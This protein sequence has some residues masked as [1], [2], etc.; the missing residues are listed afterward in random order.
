ML[1]IIKW[2]SQVTNKTWIRNWRWYD[3]VAL[4]AWYPFCSIFSFVHD[5]IFGLVLSTSSSSSVFMIPSWHSIGVCT[6]ATH[7]TLLSNRMQCCICW[8][9]RFQGIVGRSW[10]SSPLCHRQLSAEYQGTVLL[11]HVLQAV[12]LPHH[13][14]I[15]H[16]IRMD[17]PPKTYCRKLVTLWPVMLMPE[18]ICRHC[19]HTL[20]LTACRAL[21]LFCSSGLCHGY[22]STGKATKERGRQERLTAVWHRQDLS[23]GWWD[24]LIV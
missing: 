23:A 24:Y 22:W 6:A 16:I 18:A 20:R 9:F 2:K 4:G 14:T 15:C 3:C 8:N 21:F 5:H 19:S 12:C 17:F 1:W 10:G 11:L 13:H 7:S